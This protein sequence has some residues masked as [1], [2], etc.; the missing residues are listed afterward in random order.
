MAY[1]VEPRGISLRPATPR[2]AW[3][4]FILPVV[5]PPLSEQPAPQTRAWRRG[6]PWMKEGCKEERDCTE[7]NGTVPGP[8]RSLTRFWMK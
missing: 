4:R 7:I 5:L 3:V 6:S 8:S 1:C 2:A